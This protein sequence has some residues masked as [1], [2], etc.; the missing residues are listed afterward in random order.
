[1]LGKLDGIF[2]PRPSTGP[3]RLR[4]CLPLCIILRNRLKY[5]LTNQE[6]KVRR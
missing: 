3:H 1:M 2:A 6:C 5:A 4:E